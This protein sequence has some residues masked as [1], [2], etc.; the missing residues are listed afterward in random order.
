MQLLKRLLNYYRLSAPTFST[1]F[2][3]TGF[4]VT[5]R[6]RHRR[7]ILK[8]QGTYDRLHSTTRQSDNPTTTPGPFSR[9]LQDIALAS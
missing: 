5:L 2:S 1:L 3:K 4:R 7:R 9:R 6:R 8:W